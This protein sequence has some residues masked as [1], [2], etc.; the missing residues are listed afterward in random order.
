MAILKVKTEQYLTAKF[1]VHNPSKYK[2]RRML[3]AMN[4]VSKNYTL[5]LED[6]SHHADAIRE[7]SMINTKTGEIL[8]QPSEYSVTKYIRD[9]LD[10]NDER[11]PVAGVLRES[12]IVEV[13]E[14]ILSYLSL[15]VDNSDTS[16]PAGK[17][18]IDAM[19]IDELL[20]DILYRMPLTETEENVLEKEKQLKADLRRKDKHYVRPISYGRYREAPLLR[21]K[22]GKKIY[23]AI[24][25]SKGDKITTF[26]PD[27]YKIQDNEKFTNQKS[28]TTLLLPLE[29]GRWHFHRFFAKG[30][31]KTAK[32]YFNDDDRA[33]YLNY[34]FLIEAP[35]I[36]PLSFLGIDRGKVI[37]GAYGIVDFDNMVL[38]HGTAVGEKLKQQLDDLDEEIRLLQEQGVDDKMIPTNKWR[39]VVNKEIHLMANS[40][41]ELAVKHKSVIVFEDLKNI[42]KT[43]KRIIGSKRNPFH[44]ALKKSQYAN[45]K[46]IVEYKANENGLPVVEVSAAY[47]SQTCSSCG[48]QHKDNRKSQSEFLCRQCGNELNA[49]INASIVIAKKA[50]W[51]YLCRAAKGTYKTLSEFISEYRRT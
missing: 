28:S 29:M 49:D 30:K 2:Q 50:N 4:S 48:Y 38:E 18:N 34:T 43:K 32:L 37:L 31:P 11:Y 17:K 27:L 20:Q 45:L 40:I 6:L 13:T 21:T 8:K 19:S 33:F 25:L 36:E 10:K 9:Y 44:K 24:Q 51:V 47:T 16:F 15:S 22:D 41:I 23:A 39:N 46:R 35:T 42:M 3:D 1:K 5:L 26:P 7:A 12:L 14:S